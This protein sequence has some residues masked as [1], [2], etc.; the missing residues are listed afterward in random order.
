LTARQKNLVLT[1]DTAACELIGQAVR[2]VKGT[3]PN[4]VL[5]EIDD[6]AHEAEK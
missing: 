6:G 2:L 1:D 4:H 5:S 3:T